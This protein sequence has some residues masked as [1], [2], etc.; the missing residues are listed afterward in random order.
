VS[1]SLCAAAAA[2]PVRFGA[3]LRNADGTVREPANS[4]PPHTCDESGANAPT[5]ACT[6]VAVR[7]GDTGA[8]AGHVTAPRTGYITRISLIS[9]SAGAV[10]V[11]L[12]RA[13]SIDFGQGSGQAKLDTSGPTLHLRGLGFSTPAQIESFKVHVRVHRGDYL[14]LDSASLSALTCTSGSTEQLL[15]SP[16]LQVG[17]GFADSS[18]ADNCTM[19]VQAT[20]G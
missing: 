14:A 2:A 4:N 10:R 11:K 9:G 19:L 18:S 20:I 3:V 15:F 17:G 13:R 6:H 7:Y 8:V 12:V 5:P 1:L 16:V